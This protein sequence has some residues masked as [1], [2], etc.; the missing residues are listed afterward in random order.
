MKNRTIKSITA[1]LALAIVP[2]SALAGPGDLLPRPKHVETGK[3]VLPI[4]SKV[5]ITDPTSTPALRRAIAEAGYKEEK[6]G[7][8]VTVVT[9]PVEGASDYTLAGYPDEAY[10][11]EVSPE[12]IR[13][14]APE[15]MG[16]VRAAQTLSQLALDAPEG[17]ATVTVTDWPAFKLRGFLHDVGRSF[18]SIDELKKEID[19]L[20]AFKIN[21]FHWH[22]TEN[23]A[24]RFEVKSFPQLTSAEYM[25]R[26]PGMYYTQEECRELE[27]YAAERGVTIIPEIDMP[28][29]SAVFD[30]AMGFS[31]LS[32]E[33]KDAL[34]TILVEVAEAF[35]LAP[36]IHIGGDEKNFDDSF[37]I[38]MAEYTAGLGRKVI[39]WNT[40]NRPSKLVDP[41]VIPV[42]MVTNWAT[43]GR[44]VKGIPNVDMRYNYINHF[45]VFADVVGIYKSTIFGSQTGNEDIAGTITAIWNDTKVPTQDDIINQNNFYASVLASAERAWA[46][47]GESYIEEG[48]TTLP[49]S[50]PEYDE[51]A[52]WERRFL[53]HKD[54]SLKDE[55]IPYVRQTDV[56]WN[57]GYQMSNGGDPSVVGAFELYR[58]SISIP[59][60]VEWNGVVYGS[61]PAAGAGIYLRHIWHPIVK[62]LFEEVNDSVTVHAWT[63]IYSP[64]EQDAGALIEFYTFSRSGNEHTAEAGQWD[65]RGSRIWLNGTEIAPPVWEQPDM[66]VPQ[67][68]ATIGLTN[69]NLSARPAE[70]I[71]LR[72]GWN[73]VFMRLPH[74]GSNGAGRDKWQFTFVVTDPDG[75]HALDGI[76][77]D[78][79][80]SLDSPAPDMK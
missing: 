20:S 16:V 68:H 28:G 14:T 41:A 36:Y 17:I 52:D 3:G 45:D 19:L 78:P 23:Q 57:V 80:A 75:R 13:I 62:G 59:T 43:S 15:S 58:D 22:L 35:P 70:K 73:R 32:Q 67:D 2:S 64:V 63:N 77:Y 56:K 61:T 29:H 1:A 7:L 33:G 66:D 30:R 55:L 51:F 44:L 12:G 49:V 71:H 24:W 65:R 40:Y 6:G 18:I 31:M 54:H 10:R 11:L 27:R 26:Y 69:E 39:I 53:F 4:G 25:T 42:D 79:D 8:P 72:K 37:I 34:R 60:E 47:G 50:G 76:V 9:A 74:N 46:G 38:D 5:T 48:G 21:T